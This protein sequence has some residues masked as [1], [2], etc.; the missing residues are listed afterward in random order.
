MWEKLQLLFL[1]PSIGGLSNL[2]APPNLILDISIPVLHIQ[3]ASTAKS[4]SF[5][6]TG[7][8]QNFSICLGSP[9]PIFQFT[10]ALTCEKILTQTVKYY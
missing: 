8:F 2:K 1:I 7:G 5:Q 3:P 10:Q 4:F 6:K 9:P